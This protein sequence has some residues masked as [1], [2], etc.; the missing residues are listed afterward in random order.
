VCDGDFS[1]YVAKVRPD[2]RRRAFLLCGDWHHADD[3]VQSTLIRLYLRWNALEHR[4]QLGAYTRRI[5]F[6]VFAS[7]RKSN[8][9]LREL[10]Q[11][12]LPEPDAHAD[13]HERLDDRLLLLSALAQL[14]P[15]QRAVIV[16]RYWEDLSA[17]QT[18][19]LLGCSSATVRSQALRALAT[20]R[21]ILEGDLH[22]TMAS[23]RAGR[24]P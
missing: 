11:D 14:A 6:R 22:P 18:A 4:D 7:D 15:G 1:R 12:Q 17:E 5:L 3:L 13:A 20:L 2:L 10:V 9:W 16:L 8:R 23:I 21:A 19:H 24:R